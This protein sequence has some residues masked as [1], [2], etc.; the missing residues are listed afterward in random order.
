MER[1]N[2]SDRAEKRVVDERGEGVI[3]YFD[4]D[5]VVSR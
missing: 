2:Q 1:E 5:R 4:L 3:G